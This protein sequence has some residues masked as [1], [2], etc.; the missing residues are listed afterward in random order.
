MNNS[1]KKNTADWIIISSD[2]PW[3]D[4]WMPQVHYAF[5][6]SKRYDVVFIDPPNR[7]T[8][9][10]LFNF[11]LETRKVD[12]DIIVVRYLNLI[13]LSLGRVA[14]YLNDKINQFLISKLLN[15]KKNQLKIIM[16]RFDAFRSMYNFEN[17]ET[18]RQIFHVIDPIAGKN[19]DIPL[20][21]R[22]ELV[23]ITS[24][25]FI[26]HYLKINSNVLQIGQGVDLDFYRSPV[27]YNEKEIE[28][29]KN[30]ILLLCTYTD[31][32]DYEFLKRL[33]EK[34]SSKNITLIGPNRV[35]L[36]PKIAQF[37]SLIQL[38]NVN[39]LGAM[40][41]AKF[42]KHLD[43]CRVGLIA[44]DKS[45]SVNNLRSPLKIIGYLAAGKPVISNIDS[46]VPSLVNKG[47][48][49]AYEDETFYD[50]IEASYKE[51]L[52]FD[53]HIVNDYLSKMDYDNLLDSIFEN[54][55]EPLKAKY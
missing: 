29:S 17:R 6:L 23:L 32:I 24:P 43:S 51:N 25:K 54:L 37:D 4:V 34:F 39:W 11:K 49:Y 35:T 45:N 14:V 50:Y 13:P 1:K 31:E 40:P 48:Y 12:N 7:W 36:P 52:Q 28:Q 26:D 5:Q 15:F 41:P 30:S 46:E 3:S 16:W 42:R 20:A 38:K 33:A 8:F 2:E 9:K 10:N 27:Q 21:K 44:Y 19:L 22:A 18:T 47:I 53:K 55:D